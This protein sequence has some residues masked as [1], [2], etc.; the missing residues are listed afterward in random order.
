MYCDSPIPAS[1]VPLTRLYTVAVFFECLVEF[2]K[3]LTECLACTFLYC[4]AFND[5]IRY[6][7]IMPLSQVYLV[8][9]L[10]NRL[11]H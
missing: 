10:C 6:T 2:A 7:S 8:V 5:L 4:S 9:A 1:S 3:L 11:Y